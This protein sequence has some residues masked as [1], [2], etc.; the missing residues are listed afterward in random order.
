MSV[1]FWPLFLLILAIVFVFLELF[2][3]SGGAL[4]FLA[5]IASIASIVVAFMNGGPVLGTAW[6]A[7]SG[8]ALPMAIA[9]ALRWWPHTPFGRRIFNLPVISE[10]DERSVRWKSLV[11]QH[12]TAKSVMLPAGDIVVGGRTYDAVSEGMPIE[13]G[14]SVEITRV[15]G[16]RIVV[17]P[18][19]ESAVR[20]EKTSDDILSRPLDSLGLDALDEPLS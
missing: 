12:G 15:D 16:N 4:S 8:V 9:V 14:Q 7:V 13:A 18:S 3:P 6:L 19:T 20:E 2:L 5:A 17:R 10:E 11:G 1:L